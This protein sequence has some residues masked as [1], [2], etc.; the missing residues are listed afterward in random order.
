MSTD[1]PLSKMLKKEL[2]QY[3]K[4]LEKKAEEHAKAYLSWKAYR[5]S[6]EQ[7]EA[8]LKEERNEART[9]LEVWKSGCLEAQE[10]NQILQN[11]MSA[12]RQMMQLEL[13]RDPLEEAETPEDR[14]GIIHSVVGLLA[15]KLIE[16]ED[17]V[18]PILYE[19]LPVPRIMEIV[20][21]ERDKK[22]KEDKRNQLE[23]QL[24][25]GFFTH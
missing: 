1:K 21:E 4:E 23:S 12:L 25:Q 9:A 17:K 6:R 19:Y 18:K 16:M 2:I 5:E 15:R 14:A 13:L 3:I 10:Q 8:K 22:D 7:V 20:Q 11:R 24:P